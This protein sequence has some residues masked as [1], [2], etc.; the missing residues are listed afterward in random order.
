MTWENTSKGREVVFS[1]LLFAVCPYFKPHFSVE[2]QPA[3]EGAGCWQEAQVG[4]IVREG[5]EPR[6][7][8]GAMGDVSSIPLICPRQENHWITE[9][10]GWT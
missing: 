8:C 4:R 9:S 6:T 3:G 1:G 5:T 7:G 10:R 2:E